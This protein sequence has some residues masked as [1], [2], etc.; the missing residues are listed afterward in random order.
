MHPD[1]KFQ[2]YSSMMRQRR[3]ESDVQNALRPIRTDKPRLLDRLLF[4]AGRR[5]VNLGKA[6]QR[7]V[8]RRSSGEPRPRVGH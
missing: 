3:H 8:E 4:L 2:V 5:L 7:S 1:V 6:A